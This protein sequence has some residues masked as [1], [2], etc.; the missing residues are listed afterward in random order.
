M[1]AKKARKTQ[2]PK[3]NKSS[4]IRRV[5]KKMPTAKAAEVAAAVKREFGQTVNSDR[6]FMVKAK[7]NMVATRKRTSTQWSKGYPVGAAQWIEAIRIAQQLLK[8][9]GSVDNA[10]ALLC[11]LDTAE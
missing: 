2:D 8:V 11:A 6:I 3:K 7:K 4:A 5:I 10:A 1:A 9:T